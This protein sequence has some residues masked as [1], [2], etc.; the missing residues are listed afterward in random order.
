M[1]WNFFAKMRHG[2][3]KLK[4]GMGWRFSKCYD[5]VEYKC[6]KGIFEHFSYIWPNGVEILI[7]EI[8]IL[9]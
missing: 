1:G 4:N 2:G 5:K 6:Y 3:G 8:Y 9:Y 7:L